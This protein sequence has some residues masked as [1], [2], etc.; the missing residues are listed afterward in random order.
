M[1]YIK[2]IASFAIAA[3][4]LWSATGLCE[5]KSRDERRKLGEVAINFEDEP[6]SMDPT[7]QADAISGMWLAHLFE[8][9][10]SMDASGKR[11]VPAAAERFTVSPD[12]KTYTFFLRAGAQWHDGK[13]VTA[14]DFVYTF[15][16]LVDPKFG[17]EYA[18]IANVAQI[19]NAGSVIRGKKPLTDLGVH[20]RDERTL[21]IRLAAPVSF[22]PS[23]MTAS[24]FYPVRKDVVEKYR[25]KFATD[26]GSVIGNGPFKLTRWVHE[27]SMRVE[28][29][30]GFWNAGNIAITAIDAPVMLKDD[31]AAY[32][33][34]LTG[35]F[36]F[37]MLDRDRL[38]IAQKEK[39][40]IR[41]FTDD[42]VNWL[43]INYRSGRLFANQTLRQALRAA[44]NRTELV[45]KVWGIPGAKAAWGV[46]PDYMPGS[47]LATT[48]RK[49]NPLKWRDGDITE[50]KRLVAR[51][52]AETKQK[53]VP[54]FEIL[55]D[56]TIKGKLPV[57]Y[58]QGYLSGIFQ[59]KITINL[60]PYRTH[61]QLMRDGEFDLAW[62][63][64]A[65]DYLDA[66]TMVERFISE[67]D[68]NYGNFSNAKFDNL[69][70]SARAEGNPR[71]RMELL[72][73]AEKVLIVDVA[74]VIPA[75]QPSRAYLI[76]DG[77]EGYSHIHLGVDPDFRYARWK[78]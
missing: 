7:K 16:R 56:N 33:Q 26:M 27:T 34:F 78:R 9:L 12:G 40:S 77:L 30:A 31:G 6:P 4:T 41:T 3:A 65:P 42:S 35:G 8:G 70:R 29:F 19:E 22:F 25:D 1:S 49:E 50:A 14:N 32:N 17:S 72:G 13:P 38:R 67:N 47:S 73:Q 10:L 57:E 61:S 11:V 18:Y 51:Y 37:V 59:T 68:N 36:D 24:I 74:G 62:I 15:R 21:E 45:D 58:L 55:G 46:V 76:A 2:S 5:T 63:G 66:M 28:K 60:V 43:E 71:R 64:W 53:Q 75:Y 20:A 52:L 54:P 39:R 48:F 23:L 69:V 44:M